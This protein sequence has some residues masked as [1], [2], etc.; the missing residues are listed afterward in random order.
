VNLTQKYRNFRSYVSER[1]ENRQWLFPPNLDIIQKKETLPKVIPIR[2]NKPKSFAKI[3]GQKLR[4]C[5]AAMDILCRGNLEECW[6]VCLTLPANHEEAFVAL[7]KN[8]YFATHRIF[9]YLKKQYHGEVS[10]FYVWEY[11]K[12]GALHL[13]MAVH[14]RASLLLPTICSD[15]KRAWIRI[16]QDI[17]EMEN[18]CMFTDKSL[19][20]CVMPEQWQMHSAQIRK[21]VG[22]YF[23]KYAG[24]EESKQSWYCQKYPISRFW[25]SSKQIKKVISENSVT[26]IWDFQ[27]DLESAE[28]FHA[29]LLEKLILS[30]EIVKITKYNFCITSNHSY[31]ARVGDDGNLRLFPIE[32]KIY[33]SGERLT[34]Y[35]APKEFG[36]VLDYAKTV[37]TCF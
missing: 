5:G 31:T 24:K 11:Q 25:G 6:E 28:K 26:A 10:W 23:S 12:R 18:T 16:L 15:I 7:S 27:G 17:G 33:A 21:G 34:A 2:E 19:K 1:D 29:E 37:R 36:K 4:E 8:T 20:K 13:H 35:V 32:P 30:I 9:S 3:S 22:A 14:H